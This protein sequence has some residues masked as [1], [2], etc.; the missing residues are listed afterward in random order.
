MRNKMVIVVKTLVT[1]TILAIVFYIGV[2]IGK[3]NSELTTPQTFVAAQP[4]VEARLIERTIVKTVNKPV[5]VETVKYVERIK[6]VPTELRN[7]NGLEELKGWL[8]DNRNM[9]V[10]RFQ[11]DNSLIDCD[12][13]ALE[14]QYKALADGYIM[15]LEVIE[16]FE[17]NKLFET[18]LLPGQSLH[19]INL[20]IIDNDV[21]YIEPQT[22]EV[23]F[24]AQLD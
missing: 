23:A 22:D 2:T 13:Y 3:A 8:G 14:M 1:V 4:H 7:F 6:E 11:D 18:E 16:R 20:A 9:T 19:A 10:V 15:S 21:Y 12:D 24:V 17:Y 5:E